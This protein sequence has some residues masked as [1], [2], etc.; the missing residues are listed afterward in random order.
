MTGEQTPHARRENQS[1]GDKA[2]SRIVAPASSNFVA[3]IVTRAAAMKQIK[4]ARLI[5]QNPQSLPVV[6]SDK[7]PQRQI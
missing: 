4:E 7:K 6:C 5:G 1:S 3:R 2:G